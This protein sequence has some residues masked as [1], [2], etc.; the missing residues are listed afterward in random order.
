MA[1]KFT[2]LNNTYGAVGVGNSTYHRGLTFKTGLFLCCGVGEL[3]SFGVGFKLEKFEDAASF[4]AGLYTL[5]GFGAKQLMFVVTG[6]QFNT[7]R[8]SYQELGALIDAG[9]E[10]IKTFT[11]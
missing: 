5:T 10:V 3:S 8:K 7:R 9:A 1:Q 2:L 6:A 11:N 4:L